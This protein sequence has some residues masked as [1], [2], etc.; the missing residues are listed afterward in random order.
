MK[1]GLQ[2]FLKAH[3]DMDNY[4]SIVNP[5]ASRLDYAAKMIRLRVE[6]SN[7]LK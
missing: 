1:E 3:R 2:E 4:L 6:N 7:K 5:I